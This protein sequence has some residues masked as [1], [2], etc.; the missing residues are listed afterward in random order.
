[1][2]DETDQYVS[3]VSKGRPRG[4]D[5]EAALHKALKIFWTHGYEPTSVADLCSAI[6]IRPPS[7]YAAFGSKAELFIEAAR[8]YERIY[9]DDTWE[10]ME[11]EPDIHNAIAHF[12]AEAA[13][14]LLSDSAP[15]GCLVVLAAINVS[16]SAPQV[17]EEV[18]KLRQ[19]GKD[20]FSE[21][22]RR[23]VTEGQLSADTE[24]DSLATVLNSL[25]EGMSIEAK[26]GVSLELLRAT[27]KHAVRLL[28]TAQAS[29]KSI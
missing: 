23:A 18:K 9:W 21:R 14:I 27:V 16:P 7:L 22:L 3:Q 8:Y 12:F 26:D 4:F 13:D 20:C 5:R 19:E 17:S 29:S 25:L 6:G 11:K 1:M 2:T 10:R 15:C 28:P 24:I